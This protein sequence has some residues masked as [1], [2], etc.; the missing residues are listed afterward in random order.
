MHWWQR[1]TDYAYEAF[2]SLYNHW[3]FMR[4]AWLQLCFPYPRIIS[5]IDD[6]GL[7]SLLKIR[8]LPRL[9]ILGPRGCISSQVRR[10]LKSQTR[11]K[12]LFPWRPLGLENPGGKVWADNI[13][14]QGRM[15]WEKQYNWLDARYKYLHDR[16]TVS[17]RRE[18]QRRAYHKRRRRWPMLSKRT[19][20]RR[21]YQ[22]VAKMSWLGSSMSFDPRP[23]VDTS[24][25]RQII[26]VCY[27]R[28]SCPSYLV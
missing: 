19:G 24:G 1:A 17:A 6:P 13:K 26:S 21:V 7:W 10:I 27:I 20:R 15:D 22:V 4:I 25:S 14:Q 3:E 2:E 5:S 12:K 9:T 18:E 23:R 11:K 8:N 28:P 16:R